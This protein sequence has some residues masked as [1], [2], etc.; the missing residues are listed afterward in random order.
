MNRQ[1]TEAV[2][3][4]VTDVL[5]PRFLMLEA[6]YVTLSVRFNELLRRL[7][8]SLNWDFNDLK[9]PEDDEK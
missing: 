2:M 9:V 1:E 7:K 8:V 5:D 4:G 6:K 3:Q